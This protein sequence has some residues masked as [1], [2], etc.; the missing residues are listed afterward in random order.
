MINFTEED[1]IKYWSKVDIKSKDDCWEWLAG[2]NADGYGN[3]YCD[4]KTY[5]ASRLSWIFTNGPIPEGK[6]CLHKCDNR[7]CVNPN[8]LYIGTHSDN[9]S[10]REWRNPG[11]SGR[12]SSIGASGIRTV[13]KLFKQ[14]YSQKSISE[15]F[16]LSTGQIHRLCRGTSG[17]HTL[18][19]EEAN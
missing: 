2:I 9:N 6:L 15:C 7:K 5:S 17:K 11:T 12:Q 18:E 16:G 13:Q 14:G 4:Y 1:I 3:F 10:D 19:I 8:H